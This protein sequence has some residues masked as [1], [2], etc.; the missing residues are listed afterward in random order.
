MKTSLQLQSQATRAVALVIVLAMLVLLSGLLVAFMTSVTTEHNSTNANANAVATRQIAENTTNLVIAQIR[1]A[2]TR[3][4]E[5]ATWASQPGAIRVLSGKAGGKIIM[6]PENGYQYEYVPGTDVWVYK[7]YSSEQMKVKADDYQPGSSGMKDEIDVIGKWAKPPD[8]RTMD[9]RY[10]ELNEPVLTPRTDLNTGDKQYV[11]PRYPIIDP[12]ASFDKNEKPPATA[13][14]PGIV[15]GFAATSTNLLATS[16]KV[17]TVAG[18][19]V[20][21]LPMPAQWLYVLRDGSILGPQAVAALGT[22]LETNPIV[23]RTAFWVDDESC[24]VNVNTASEGT[25]WDTPVVSTEQDS[26]NVSSTGPIT[27][28]TTSLSLAGSQPARGEYQR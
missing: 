9:P 10:V 18:Q 17:L 24:K 14:T 2:T 4:T 26:G 11:D 12:R 20:P 22:K 25:F 27:S 6:A 28:S 3:Y 23:G 13:G 15:E 5:S 1:E 7:L 19:A 21:S 16:S 8:T